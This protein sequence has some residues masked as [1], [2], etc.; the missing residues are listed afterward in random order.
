MTATTPETTAARGATPWHLWAI[1]GLSLLWNAF[2]AYDYV[3][4]HWK[5]DAYFQQMGMTQAQVALLHSYPAWMTAVWAIGV[6]GSVLGSVLLLARSRWATTAFLV[7]LAG[8]V[9]AF[10]FNYRTGP[11]AATSQSMTMNAVIFIVCAALAAYAWT[12]GKR[13][14]LR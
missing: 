5:G 1:G 14:V 11:D 3:M 4:S 7:S 13:G 9:V 12:M 8:I 6:W 10:G 2:G